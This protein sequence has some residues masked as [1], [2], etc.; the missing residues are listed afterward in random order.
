MTD[1]NMNRSIFSSCS[2]T[3]INILKT[4]SLS[5]NITFLSITSSR[6]FKNIIL[7]LSE[8]SRESRGHWSGR[9][10]RKL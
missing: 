7:I 8:I 3:K 10:L 1:F 9:F 4:M 5:K 2:R 6:G